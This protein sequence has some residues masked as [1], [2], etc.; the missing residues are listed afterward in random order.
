MKRSPH[1]LSCLLLLAC[2]LLPLTAGA[3]T[4]HALQAPQARPTPTQPDPIVRAERAPQTPQEATEEA[5]D[6]GDSIRISLLTCE[7]GPLIYMLFGHSALRV[8][9]PG[10]GVDVVFNYGLFNFDAPYFVLRFALGQTDYRLGVERYRD[11]IVDNKRKGLDVYQQELNLNAAEK[12]RLIDLLE[13][14]YRPENRVYRYSYFYDNCA[15]RP[16]DKV[17]AAVEG[18]IAYADDMETTQ[19]GLTLRDMI[20]RYS[21]GHPWSQLGMNLCLGSEADRPASRRTLMFVP[22][23]LAEYWR[24]ARIVE[25]DGSE[26]PL[27][28]REKQVLRTGITPA[29]RYDHGIK[30]LTTIVIVLALTVLLTVVGV[31]KGRQWWA[32]DLILLFLA[33]VAGCVVAFL[34]FFSEHPAVSPNYLLLVLHPLHLLALPFVLRRL[35]KGQLS[36]YMVLIGVVLIFFIVFMPL[37]P[38]KFDAAVVPLALCLLTRSVGH[39]W[40]RL[41]LQKRQFAHGKISRA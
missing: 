2:T 22:F 5:T 41:R 3:R 38:Q 21:E 36:R 7:S 12:L 13:E 33:G 8:E 32:I 39:V 35:I 37:I 17:E 40:L 34:V 20:V 4:D 16:R 6:T 18:H 14:N 11:F 23:I 28:A 29:D 25:P 27:V 10:R 26:R 1:L 15:T 24:T 30:P 19:T 31:R 9:W